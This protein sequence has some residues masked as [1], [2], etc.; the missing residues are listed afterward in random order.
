MK[1]K[2]GKGD[3]VEVISGKE[4]G[5]KGTVLGLDKTRMRV[6]IQGVCIQTHYSRE[7]GIQTREGFIHYSNVKLVEKAKKDMKA[8]KKAVA[9]SS[10]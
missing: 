10:T 1:L 2:I 8:K 3:T 7:D 9:K 5:R 6:K 4:R